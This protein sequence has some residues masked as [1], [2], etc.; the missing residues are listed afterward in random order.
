MQSNQILLLLNVQ[1]DYRRRLCPRPI[2][3]DFCNHHKYRMII[4]SWHIRVMSRAKIYQQL[5]ILTL[6]R[7]A[8]IP[9]DENVG[10][11]PYSQ[12]DEFMSV[13]R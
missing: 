7:I 10:M 6:T 13:W 11:E 12:L 5:S 2:I 3:T 4:L 8:Y 9:R 1:L